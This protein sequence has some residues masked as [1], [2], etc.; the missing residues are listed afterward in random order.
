MNTIEKHTTGITAGLQEGSSVKEQRRAA[1]PEETVG[2]PLVDSPKMSSPQ[3]SM[4][5]IATSRPY[6]MSI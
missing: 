5:P 1:Y 4:F 3:L 2:K 6:I